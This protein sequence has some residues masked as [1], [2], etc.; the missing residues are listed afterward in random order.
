MK[1]ET[2]EKPTTSFVIDI[3]GNFCLN[4]PLYLYAFFLISRDVGIRL[5]KILYFQGFIMS[6]TS[7]FSLK[8]VKDFT[9]KEKFNLTHTQTDIMSYFVNLSSWAYTEG[10]GYYLAVTNKI[11][12]DLDLQIK[13]VEACILK[14]KKLNLIKVKCMLVKEWSTQTKHRYIA[15]TSKGKF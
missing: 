5:L 9:F 14:L 10:S 1:S 4:F 13:T 3:L 15:I 6:N 7:T 12:M 2:L 11:M 8:L